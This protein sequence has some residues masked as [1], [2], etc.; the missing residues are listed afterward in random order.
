M[1][2]TLMSVAEYLHSS[3]PGPDCEYVDG[4]VVERSVGEQPHSW[5]QGELAGYFRDRRKALLTY[6]FTE[7][8]VQVS[9]TRYRVP[10]LCVY[11]GG[12][13]DERIFTAP[14]FLAVEI[15]SRD[16]RV[17]DLQE[18]IGDYLGLGVPFIWVIDP[19]IGE[20]HTHTGEGSRPGLRTLNPDMELSREELLAI[21]NAR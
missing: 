18:K 19:E 16:D 17:K 14:P 12:R 3:F 6:A 7:Q 13:P 8:R 5:L 9:A 1:Q 10:D 21:I 2:T 4:V 20:G 15:L 11:V